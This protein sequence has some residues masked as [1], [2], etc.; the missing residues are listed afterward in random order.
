MLK[1][2]ILAEKFASD[3][4]WYFDT[5]V[6]LI[7]TAGNLITDDVWYRL[8]QMV[9]GFNDDENPSIRKYAALK[10][11]NILQKPYVNQTLVK[12]SAYVL[13]EFSQNYINNGDPLV[14]E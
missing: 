11:Y 6:H 3:L 7:Q 9:T 8:L 1:V 12:L 10:L 5:I 4:Q 13:A 14:N 2:A